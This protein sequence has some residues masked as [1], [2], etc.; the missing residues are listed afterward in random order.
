MARNGWFEGSAFADCQG[1]GWETP[2]LLR[3]CDQCGEDV[4]DKC[5][6]DGICE[7]CVAKNAEAVAEENAEHEAREPECTC[8]QVAVDHFDHSGCE[9]HGGKAPN[10]GGWQ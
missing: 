8:V 3:A 6:P 1:C 5:A 7:K 4:C 9:A 10:Y 2:K